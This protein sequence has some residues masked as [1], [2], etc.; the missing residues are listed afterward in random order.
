M[1][2]IGHSNHPIDRFLGLLQQHGIE[3]LIDVRSVPYSRF[4]P[5]FAIH[6]LRASLSEA[7]CAYVFLGEELGG[8]PDGREFYDD[9]GHVLYGRRAE[10]P[11]FR[12]G[13]ERLVAEAGSRRVAIM[14]SEENPESCHR[15]LLVARALEPRGMAVDH[16]RGDGRLSRDAELAPI[17][18]LQGELFDRDGWRSTRPVR[19]GQ[20]RR[21]HA[22]KRARRR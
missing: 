18:D 1:F 10:A 13:I 5:Q 6:A 17:A 15:R 14:C 22:A 11:E 12:A 19:P 9:E 4:S 21:E 8:R 2:S 20:P 7:G 16:I 3:S